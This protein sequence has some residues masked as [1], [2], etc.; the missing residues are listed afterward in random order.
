[1]HQGE[2]FPLIERHVDDNPISQRATDGYVNGTLMCK[3]VNKQ[4]NDYKRL[5]ATQG[6]L[7]ELGESTGIPVDQLI[8]IIKTGPNQNRGTWVHPQVA[9]NL[10]QWASPK[11]AVLV[12]QWVFEWMNGGG[13]QKDAL[14]DHI[15][16]YL[17]NRQKIPPTHFSMLDQMTLRL[18]A[19]VEQ[20]GYM[21]PA[22]M[23]P[24]ISLGR[25]FSE[26]LREHGH[27]PDS[28]PS[29]DHQFIDHRP[30]VPA[31]LYP[32][33]LMTAFNM[34]LEDWIRNG[35][36]LKYFSDR[37][38]TAIEPLKQIYAELLQPAQETAFN[39]SLKQALNYNPKL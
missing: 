7:N 8:Q 38:K 37:D 31:R 4:L 26:W 25:M 12:S 28:F 6:F 9:I 17:V 23:M 15:K 33:E 22:K 32:N 16:R 1:M 14:P 3:A 10:G 2:L 27:D 19:S 21:I 29:Y 24:D 35:K 36:A 18:L 39:Q 5:K 11:F 13:A 34:Q 20:K 30:N